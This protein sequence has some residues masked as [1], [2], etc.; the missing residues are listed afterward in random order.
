MPTTGVRAVRVGL[1]D[2]RLKFDQGFVE[3]DA[4]KV[5]LDSLVLKMKGDFYRVDPNYATWPSLF[6]EN[7]Y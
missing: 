6:T 4:D 5:M 3:F 7:P 2:F 1:T